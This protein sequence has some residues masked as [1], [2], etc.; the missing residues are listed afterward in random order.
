ML[1]EKLLLDNKNIKQ[2]S[3]IYLKNNDQLLFLERKVTKGIVKAGQL[4]G[5]GG[6]IEVGEDLFLSAKREF[7][8]ESGL[9]LENLFFKGNFVLVQKNSDAIGMIYLFVATEYSGE[10]ITSNREGELVW[11][12]IKD[13]E[14]LNNLAEH[15][16]LFLEKILE[17]ES[18]IYSGIGVY[19]DAQLISYS[20]SSI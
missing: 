17:E 15:Q 7:K 6:K 12:D 18:S 13:L 20:E 14:N 19:D 16:K 5:L 1:S 9:S 2:F 10:L 11:Y 4:L 3:L 8:E